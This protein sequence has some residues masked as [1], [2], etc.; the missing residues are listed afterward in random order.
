MLGYEAIE[1]G[2]ENDGKSDL[3][4]IKREETRAPGRVM[5]HDTESVM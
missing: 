1:V 3:A 5:V 4:S 2:G